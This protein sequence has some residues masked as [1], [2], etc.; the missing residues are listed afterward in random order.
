MGSAGLLRSVS[1]ISTLSAR[2]SSAMAMR[3]LR[4]KGDAGLERRIMGQ[5]LAM[6]GDRPAT[7]DVGNAVE[8]LSARD[9]QVNGFRALALL[10]GLDVEADA[11]PL[12]EGFQPRSEERR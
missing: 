1:W 10:V 4:P 9:D 3:T 7:C 2:P 5:I 12:V 8:F 11:L 6:A